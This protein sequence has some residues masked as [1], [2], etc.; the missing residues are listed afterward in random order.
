MMGEGISG[1]IDASDGTTLR[2]QAW[3]VGVDFINVSAVPEAPAWVMMLAGFFGPGCVA[4]RK[5]KSAPTA[6]AA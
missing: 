3:P 4:C 5:T 2:Q 1:D 6:V